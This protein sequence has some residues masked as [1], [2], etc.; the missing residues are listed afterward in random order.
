MKYGTAPTSISIKVATTVVLAL[1]P[2]FLSLSPVS[3]VFLLPAALIAVLSVGCYLRTPVAYDVS[4]S[5]L[6]ILF[7]LGSKS[8]GPITRASIVERSLGWSI[9]LW[10]NGGLFAGTGIFWNRTWGLFRAYV[11]TSNTSNL[12]L[13]ETQKGKVLISPDNATEAIK[14]AMGS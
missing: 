7:R 6:A 13:M 4:P 9:R 8:F 3:K 11:T 10:G 5:G 14:S 12:V 2:I 1:T